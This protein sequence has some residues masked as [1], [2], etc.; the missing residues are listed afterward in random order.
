MLPDLDEKRCDFNVGKP[1][2]SGGRGDMFNPASQ[3][4]QKCEKTSFGPEFSR[5]KAH[6][7]VPLG[8]LCHV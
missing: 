5:A 6:I 7:S 2:I 3:G 8:E 4:S 1:E